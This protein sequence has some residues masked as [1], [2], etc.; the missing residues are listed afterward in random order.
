MTTPDMFRAILADLNAT[1]DGALHTLPDGCKVTVFVQNEGGLVPV[2]KV[3]AVEF[4]DVYMVLRSDEG[5]VFAATDTFA[6][7]RVEQEASRDSKVG[8]R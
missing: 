1:A 5:R 7:L 3:T 6:L 4:K 2:T 8:F